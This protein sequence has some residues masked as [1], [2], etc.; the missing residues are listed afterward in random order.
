MSDIKEMIGETMVSVTGESGDE[1]M[2]FTAES[3]KV[4]VFYHGQDCC[5]NVSIYD[6]VGDVTDLIGSQIKMAECV[7]SQETPDGCEQPSDSYTWTFYKFATEKGY[8]TVRWLGE[9]NGY[10]SESVEFLILEA[11][12]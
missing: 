8:V 9:S 6:I 11:A 5:E 10:Y 12:K 2:E 3:G 1:Q 4:F 7:E